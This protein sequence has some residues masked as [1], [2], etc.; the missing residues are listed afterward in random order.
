MSYARKL[1]N[2]PFLVVRVMRVLLINGHEV[3]LADIRNKKDPEIGCPQLLC[4]CG[5]NER[6]DS[7]KCKARRVVEKELIKQARKDNGARWQKMG[8][9]EAI[10][11]IFDRV[12]KKEYL[13]GNSSDLMYLQ[14]VAELLGVAPY[15]NLRPICEELIKEKKLGLCGNILI[16]YECWLEDQKESAKSKGCEE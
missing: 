10:L 11:D 3:V 16:S 15:H 13:G 14:T 9:K 12:S 6:I 7:L 2:D 4:E 1:C 5:L 8:V